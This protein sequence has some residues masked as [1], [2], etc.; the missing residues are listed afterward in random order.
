MTA[1]GYATVATTY[2]QRGWHP[3]PIPRGEKASPPAGTTG[4]DGKDPTADDIASWA[5]IDAHANVALRMPAGVIGIDVDDYDGKGGAATLADLVGQFGPLP[6][7]W[8]STSRGPDQP[9]RIYFLRCPVDLE[10]PGT[11]GP[12]IEAIQRHHRYAVAAPSTRRDT[13]GR[14]RWYHP[15]GSKATTPPAVA[16]LPELP[17]TWAQG[18]AVRPRATDGHNGTPAPATAPRGPLADDDSIAERINRDNDWHTLLNADGWTVHHQAGDD[19]HWTRPGKDTRLG[20]SAVLHEPDG[21]F[22]VF[23]TG[24]AELQQAW[25]TNN[26]DSWAYSL[27]G[28]LAAT[29]FAGNRSQLAREARLADNTRKLSNAPLRLT[30]MAAGEQ[31]AE[32][33]T[34]VHNGRQLN[35]VVADAIDAIDKTNTP[36]TTF[37]RSGQLVRLR[38]DEN[39]RPMIETLR[40]EHVRN[41]LSDAALWYR[42]LKDGGLTDTAP[43]LDVC[44]SVLARGQWPYPALAGV[45]ELPVLRPDGTFH[46][47]HGHD[48][49]TRLYHWHRGQA[50]DQIPDTPSGDELAAAVALVDELFGD[51]PWDTA[52]DRAN[53]WA[54]LLTPLVRAIIGQV[55]MALIDAPEPGTGKGLLVKVCSIVTTGHA[56]ALMAWPSSD[57]ELEKKVSA[58]LMAGNTVV[59]FDNVEGMIK[60]PTLAAVLTADSWQGRVLGRSEVVVVPNRATWAA[61][62]NNIDV[63]G[64][65][66]RRC[67][68]IRLDA[69]QAQ[70]WLRTGW[71]HADLEGWALANRSRLLHALCTIVRSWWVAGKP[72]A[73]E[74]PAMGGYSAWVRCVGGI[75]EHAGVGHFLANLAEFHASADR[76]AQAWEAYLTAWSDRVGEQPVTVGEL[77]AKMADI[78]FGHQ[79]REVLPEDIA[80]YWDTPGFSRRFS[81]ALRRRVGRHYGADGMH[82]VEMPRDRRQVAIYCVTDRPIS[83]QLDEPDAREL[84][85]SSTT[86][87]DDDAVTRDNATTAGVAGVTD[88]LIGKKT[89][90]QDAEILGSGSGANSRDS[91]HS[92]ASD[93]D[94]SGL[95]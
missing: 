67:Y 4:R 62:G 91:L 51:F 8:S 39:E 57:E 38:E 71:K 11:L 35:D 59:V 94:D 9:S 26:G 73:T 92:R 58:T 37:V 1:P 36:P 75:L 46:V 78:Q 44:V 18:L 69:R 82:L 88:G 61:T 49:A 6:A 22:V 89:Y 23:T 43:P 68:R 83:L 20:T 41:V 70:P 45:V 29:R 14:Y 42:S 13:G 87:A 2:H 81:I 50:Y 86:P 55:P 10:L 84:R 56:A 53:A 33:A 64:D 48:Q 34:I 16:E 19:T 28:Y 90:P 40:S 30:E 95:F 12:G 24:V 21:P 31:P 60:S 79:L 5:A 93:L 54:L 63:G 77:I 17:A 66:A 72:S 52:A 15:D 47:D 76:E 7:T 65:L 25:A 32:R 74:L 3:L 80:G 27:F 85:G